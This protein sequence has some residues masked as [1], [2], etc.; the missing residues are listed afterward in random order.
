VSVSDTNLMRTLRGKA[1]SGVPFWEVWFAM[2][3]LAEHLLGRPVVTLDD[4]IELARRLGWEYLTCYLP[5]N[6]P[7]SDTAVASDGTAHYV[8][9]GIIPLDELYARPLPDLTQAAANA[10]QVVTAAHNA[11]MA[12]IAYVPWCFHAANTA[13][14]LE[15]LS[16]LVYDD[17]D[18]LHAL[19]EWV[20]EGTR[21]LIR[22]IIVP[23]GFDVVLF[24]GDCS[25]K[26]GL[27]VRPEVF[28][29]L[30]F[31]RTLATLQ[32]LKEAGIAATFHSDGRV[33]DLLPI[34]IELGFDGFHGVEAQANDLGEVK[35]RFGR[36]VTLIGNMDVVFLTHASVDQV[37][38]ETEKML[39]IGTP[40]GRYIAACNTSPLDYIPFPNYL[41]MVDVITHYGGA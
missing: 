15:H 7:G 17:I 23:L 41:A 3:G 18:Y 2:H 11:G 30:V 22:E 40:G 29:E 5:G 16:Y 9:H 14:G 13:L 31:E 19:F 35:R 12:A 34:L 20:E 33:D 27:M 25:Y 36:D 10:Q 28:R 6:H 26:N 24:D 32:P 37:R 38:R 8:Q 1:T 39:D 4:H 21:R